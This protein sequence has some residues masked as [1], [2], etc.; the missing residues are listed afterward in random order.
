MRQDGVLAQ[1][2]RKM[3]RHALGQTAG[4]DEDQRGAVLRIS[5]AVR[6]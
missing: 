5:S 4:V 3:M 2:L 6:S 1:S